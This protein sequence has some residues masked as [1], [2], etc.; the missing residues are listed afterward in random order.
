M[1][2]PERD[3]EHVVAAFLTAQK[4]RR[5][6]ADFFVSG[7]ERTSVE[8]EL[9]R[10]LT[11]FLRAEGLDVVRLRH[12]GEHE[13]PPDC[14]LELPNGDLIGIE[15]TELVDQET[16]ERHV[17]AGMRGAPFDISDVAGWPSCRLV[18]GIRTRLEAKDIPAE[19]RK[20]G[21]YAR[22]IVLIPTDEPMIVYDMALQALQGFRFEARAVDEAYLLISYHPT[23]GADFPEG[24]P[25]IKIDVQRP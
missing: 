2:L 9:A 5:G 15:I 4:K 24:W 16:V 21:P 14:E 12:R 7:Y 3:L 19:R 13:D 17:K 22:Y 20:G 18:E 6:Y 1:P 23:D 11:R 25:I 10:I 8:F